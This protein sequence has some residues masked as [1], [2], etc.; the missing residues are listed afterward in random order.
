MSEIA[1]QKRLLG[2]KN[3]VLI[4]SSQIQKARSS[5]RLRTA[6]MGYRMGPSSHPQ[7]V[8]EAVVTVHPHRGSYTANG[9]APLCF[10]FQIGVN[11]V[12]DSLSLP[13]ARESRAMEAVAGKKARATGVTG[14]GRV[15]F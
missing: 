9:A 10:H 6:R 15:F 12:N 1:P 11:G 14:K 5:L 8:K 7:S 13:G 2:A 4:H 3:L